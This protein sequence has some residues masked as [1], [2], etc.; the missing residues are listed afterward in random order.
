MTNLR[1]GAILFDMKIIFYSLGLISL[2]TGLSFSSAC[3]LQR[4]EGRKDII[5]TSIS[6][7]ALEGSIAGSFLGFE[8][9]FGNSKEVTIWFRVDSSDIES[10]AFPTKG[11]RFVVTDDTTLKAQFLLDNNP[12][13]LNQV[14]FDLRHFV[15]NI[16]I[17]GNVSLIE[18]LLK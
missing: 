7:P 6:K 1:L 3:P 10:I 17:Y 11:I 12:E 8:G 2:L 9:Q 15:R 18:R 13:D 4:Y 16:S 14:P 5:A